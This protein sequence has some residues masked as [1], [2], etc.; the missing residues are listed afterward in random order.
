MTSTAPAKV[1][2][3][4]RSPEVEQRHKSSDLEL[5]ARYRSGDTAAFEVVFQRYHM[6]LRG[7]CLRTLGDEAT[8]DDMVQETF[9]RVL[10]SVDRLDATANFAAWVHRI[11]ANVCTDELRRRRLRRK[12]EA[13][14]EE[15]DVILKIPDTSAIGQPEAALE[16]Q[17]L[18]RLIWQVSRKLPERQ[19]MVLA[20][21]ELESRPYTSIARVMGITESAVE[22][23]LHRAR[24]RFREEFLLIEGPAGEEGLCMLVSKL[25]HEVGLDRMQSTQRKMVEEHIVA[26]SWCNETLMVN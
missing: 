10:R 14:G 26:C 13:N 3:E 6:Q 5:I 8:A 15:T 19:R 16:L 22:T 2:T 11:A 18:R 20:M 4:P 24:R 12:R 23:L 9:Y 7:V 17:R 25:I 1:E 21:R